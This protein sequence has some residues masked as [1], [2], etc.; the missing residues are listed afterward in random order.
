MNENGRSLSMTQSVGQVRLLREGPVERHARAVEIGACL[1]GL[2]LVTL[3]ILAWSP[4]APHGVADLRIAVTL[5]GLSGAWPLLRLGFG[6][7]RYETVFDVGSQEVRQYRITAGGRARAVLTL[8]LGLVDSV[9]ID[10]GP[11]GRPSHL[12]A[13]DAA[14]KRIHIG[15]AP[16]AQLERMHVEIVTALRAAPARAPRRRR[17]VPRA[18][19]ALA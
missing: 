1:A 7:V 2:L 19:T 5:S 8:P 3:A 15:T 6:G 16:L 12:A 17:S 11:A 13:R 18:Q 14:G 9:H 10:R 4:L